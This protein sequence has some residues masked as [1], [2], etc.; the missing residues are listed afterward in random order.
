[1]CFLP[2][3]RC[4][5]S[6][7]RSLHRLAV[8]LCIGLAVTGWHA[9][10]AQ[11]AG[12]QTYSQEAIVYPPEA[13]LSDSALAVL[14]A[15]PQK[16]IRIDFD[17]NVVCYGESLQLWVDYTD[18]GTIAPGKLACE[19]FYNGE[20]YQAAPDQTSITFSPPSNNIDIWF[21]F[22][23]DG[24]LVGTDTMRVYVT[25]RPTGYMM[26]HDTICLGN[27][28][29]VGVA[30]TIGGSAGQYWDWVTTGTTQ[31]IN[32]RP[33]VSTDYRV[34]FSQYPIKEYGYKNR[35]YTTDS[36]HV[37][38]L[39]EPDILMTGDSTVCVGNTAIIELQDASDIIWSDGSTGSVYRIDDLQDNVVL[40]V[41][42]TDRYGC[43]GVRVWTIKV[44]ERPQGEIAASS[45]T[46]N[47]GDEVTLWLAYSDG[48]SLRWF[49]HE[50]TDSLTFMPKQST[51]VF[52]DL[53][54]GQRGGCSSR[55]YKRIT[56]TNNVNFYFPTGF[57]LEGVS[58]EYKPIGVIE[59]R[60]TYYFAIYNR[61]GLRLFETRDL[62]VGW[63]GKY[64][65][66]WVHPGVY[67]YYYKETFDRFSTELTGTVTVVK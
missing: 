12:K 35:C 18:Y 5:V 4:F 66:Q 60:K 28:A 9:G 19:W 63:D 27:E 25:D 64:K 21:K 11:E 59:P 24:I 54:I 50:T 43:R 36:A 1:M 42:A 2:S 41:R 47:L 48:D 39:T 26:Q 22:Y 62:N 23:D 37:E 45:D 61:N 20:P 8:W 13:L 57:K 58:Q 40:Q 34:D 38:V 53:Y 55:I 14:A 67:V 32:D 17:A 10:L 56:V 29:T 30:G 15:T 16:P 7:A 49:N 3:I 44:V 52:A 31:F 33:L 6:A 65:G 51:D 46:I